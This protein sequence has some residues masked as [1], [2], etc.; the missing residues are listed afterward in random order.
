MNPNCLAPSAARFQRV[1]PHT[2]LGRVTNFI[3]FNIVEP[4]L[5]GS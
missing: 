3:L 5:P 4:I 1:L 2:A